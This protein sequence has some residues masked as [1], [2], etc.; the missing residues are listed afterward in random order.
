MCFILRSHWQC[1]Q[2][3]I[4]SP[5]PVKIPVPSSVPLTVCSTVYVRELWYLPEILKPVYCSTLLQGV[6]FQ[7]L[8]TSLKQL[9]LLTLLIQTKETH[10]K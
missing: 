6:E 2:P 7:G 10:F 4:H 8:Y 9:H 5:V 1:C 3:L